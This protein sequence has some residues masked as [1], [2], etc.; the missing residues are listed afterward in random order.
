MIDTI[1]K[2][3]FWTAIGFIVLTVF[4]LTIGQTLPY[5]FADY[6]IQ[7]KFYDT[8]I[9]GL[10][11]AVLLTLFGTIKKEN[12]KTKNWIWGGTTVLT[13]ILCFVG[14][15]FMIM[16]FGF[17]AW[18]T[19]TILYKHKTEN[20]VIKKQLFDIGAFGYGG[21]RIVETKPFLKIW[22]LPTQV[23]T[24]T[25]NKEEWKFVNEEGDMKFP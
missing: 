4:S 22:I 10:P 25:I 19:E 11:F 24:Q 6:K 9:F 12:S 2:I 23:D 13:A 1:K 15:L 3:I 18:T 16:S 7:H 21:Q 20:R 17:G 14:Q 5:E 8:I